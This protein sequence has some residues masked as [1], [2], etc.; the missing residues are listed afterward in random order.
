[1]PHPAPRALLT[2]TALALLALAACR[3]PADDPAAQPG[4]AAAPTAEVAP[5]F[6]LETVDGEAYSLG[7]LRGH[8]VI[9]NFWATWCAPC[10]VEVPELMEVHEE[11]A[12]QG[13]FVLGVSQDTGPSV[14]DDVRDFRDMFDV[15]Y[16]MLVDPGLRVGQ[17]Y[18]GIDSLPTTLI[19]DRDGNIHRR[20]IG[21]LSRERL[22][23]LF[24]DLLDDPAA[25]AA[26]PPAP[27]PPAA[28]PVIAA[29]DT[30]PAERPPLA[31]SPERAAAL[32][33]DGAMVVDLR[34][35]R[36]R[37]ASGA[38]PFSLAVSPAA[39]SESALPANL[40]APIVFVAADEEVSWQAA[41]RAAAWG[42]RR[43]HTLA[44]GFA[45]WLAAGLPTE[46]AAF[47]PTALSEDEP[48]ED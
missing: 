12:D 42:Y 41:S 32:I 8:V 16:P 39:F 17:A 43:A 15:N 30:L 5:D 46:A 45:A 27:P 20:Q 38:I 40:A 1:L 31:I 29:A 48:Q 44:G 34:T 11:F 2:L 47:R 36:D 37:A 4:D 14:Y 25:P 6:T 33:G 13:V 21:L 26:A 22:L 3:Q 24:V 19:I 7:D 9:L 10:V 18:G 35:D 28:E 23:G